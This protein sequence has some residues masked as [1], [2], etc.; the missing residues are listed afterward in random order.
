M[1]GREQQRQRGADQ[2]VL[3]VAARLLLDP[4]PLV[5]VDHAA[6]AGVEHAAGARV[7][8][9]QPRRADV[10]AVAPARALDLAVGLEDVVVEDL[11]A[12]L[13][14]PH[15]VVDVVV[16]ELARREVAEVLVDPVRHEAADDAVVPPAL[17]ADVGDP[18]LRRVPVV[19]DVVVVE[20]HRRGHGREQPAHVGLAPRLPVQARVL[21]E[22]GHGLA[23]RHLG[24][25]AGADELAHVRRDLVGVD[26][27]AEQDHRLGPLGRAPAPASGARAPAARR[28]R[29]RRGGRPWAA[30]AAARAARRRGRSRRRSASAGPGRG[31]A[32]RW[33]DTGCRAA[34]TPSRRRG[35]PRRA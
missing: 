33:A 31:C 21:L 19:V 16:V 30:S 12:V 24:V 17:A 29:A 7:D 15:A 13:G 8:H 10:A 4:L 11:R 26:L 25:A 9:D 5:L 28:P 20:D 3:A 14:L 22:V 34:A 35:G 32:P 18:G 1:P 27:V 6:L 2:Q 23:R